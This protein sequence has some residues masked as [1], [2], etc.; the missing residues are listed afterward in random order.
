MTRIFL[1]AAAMLLSVTAAFAQDKTG[2]K[3]GGKASQKFLTEAIQGN[4]AESQMGEL[5]QKNG[6]S[7]EVKSYGQ[8]LAT[9]HKAANQKATAAATSQGMNP[10]AGP[11]AKQKADYDKMAKMN[12]AA[13]D[14][15]FAQHMVQDHRKDIKAYGKA[16]KKQD[17]AGQYAQ[18]TLPTLQKHLEN[19]QS[20][21]KQKTTAR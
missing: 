4:F 20:L 2:G 17:A 16:A 13:F 11:N 15:M 14:K 8:M 3:A 19:A 5:A 7:Q 21:Q 9:D 10:P 6:Q 1:T 12:G 18:E